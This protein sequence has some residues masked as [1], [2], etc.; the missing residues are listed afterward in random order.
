MT[1]II[2][3]FR[4]ASDFVC[5][6]IKLFLNM[7]GEYMNLDMYIHRVETIANRVVNDYKYNE[8]R[9]PVEPYCLDEKMLDNFLR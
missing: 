1:G 9:T 5:I 2:N 6:K 8:I 3:L 7:E 4:H